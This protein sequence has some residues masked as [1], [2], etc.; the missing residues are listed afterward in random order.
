MIVS[1]TGEISKGRCDTHAH[2]HTHTHTASTA[3]YTKTLSNV[4]DL[5]HKREKTVWRTPRKRVDPLLTVTPA[6]IIQPL[7]PHASSSSGEEEEEEEDAHSLVTVA[8]RKETREQAHGEF[9]EQV[10]Q[11]LRRTCH[12]KQVSTPLLIHGTSL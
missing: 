12:H 1:V 3:A 6:G 8:S 10:E 7:L 11:E 5:R 9:D 4:S 2:T